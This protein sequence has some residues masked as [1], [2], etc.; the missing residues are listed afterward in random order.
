MGHVKVMMVKHDKREIEQLRG[1]FESDT[2]YEYAGCLDK[3]E[4]AVQKISD[5]KPDI[6]VVDEVVAGTDIMDMVEAT[7]KNRNLKNVRIAISNRNCIM[8]AILSPLP[9]SEKIVEYPLADSPKSRQNILSN[10]TLIPKIINVC[11]K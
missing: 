10:K 11:A 6:V 5:E 7:A 4:D 3:G 8:V 1:I 9:P 2:Y